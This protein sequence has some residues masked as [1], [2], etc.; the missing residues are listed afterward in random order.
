[1]ME[2]FAKPTILLTCLFHQILQSRHKV[3]NPQ[4]SK[5]YLR[6]TN[7]KS[8]YADFTWNIYSWTRKRTLNTLTWHLYSKLLKIHH[9]KWLP[10]GRHL[11]PASQKKK[12]KKKSQFIC[13]LFSLYQERNKVYLHG[14]GCLKLPHV[15]MDCESICCISPWR[16]LCEKRAN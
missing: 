3:K 4:V 7:S 11:Q 12:K 9:S 2:T 10:A 8:T 14:E 6:S 16:E 5:Q 13:A 1:M 15:L